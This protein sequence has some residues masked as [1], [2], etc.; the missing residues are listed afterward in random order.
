[1]VGNIYAGGEG[2]INVR[3]KLFLVGN[4]HARPPVTAEGADDGGI[5][6]FED[7]YHRALVVAAVENPFNEHGVAVERSVQAHVGDKE[8]V[9]IGIFVLGNEEGKAA[10][11]PAECAFDQP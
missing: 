10:F 11:V 9:G 1:M 6:P 7:F 5:A 4:E 8:I 3:C 2:D